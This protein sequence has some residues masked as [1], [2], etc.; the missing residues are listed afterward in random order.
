[1]LTKDAGANVDLPSTSGIGDSPY[2]SATFDLAKNYTL[3]LSLH[4]T[5]R[6]LGPSDAAWLSA[7]VLPTFSGVLRRPRGGERGTA[8][9]VVD[10]MLA[11]APTV[12]A[13]RGRLFDP[14]AI[15][16]RVLE[17]RVRVAE[18]WMQ[19]AGAARQEHL[20]LEKDVLEAGM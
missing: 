9:A 18:T 11:T 19:V 14:A 13:E 2:R 10:A 4:T 16:D 6:L 15:V 17:E 1:M 20:D 3:L 7:H 12:G 5:A 8:D